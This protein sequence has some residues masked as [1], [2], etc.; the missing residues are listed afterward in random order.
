MYFKSNDT[1]FKNIM[2]SIIQKVNYKFK[3][4]FHCQCTTNLF[5]TSL[6][7]FVIVI[8]LERIGTEIPPQQ[9][10]TPFGKR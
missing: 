10:Q 7:L 6:R 9:V 8:I 2:F 1:D 5:Y 3:N 4:I